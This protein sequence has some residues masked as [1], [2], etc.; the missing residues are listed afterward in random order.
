MGQKVHEV[1]AGLERKLTF[2]VFPRINFRETNLLKGTHCLPMFFACGG[3]ARQS[4]SSFQM[5]NPSCW[6]VLAVWQSK[7]SDPG[8]AT[9]RELQLLEREAD[10]GSD[11]LMCG[12]R[13][14]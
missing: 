1:G 3:S 12:F 6:Q 9:R 14:E 13:A 2:W 10:L 4:E 7:V 11:T 5:Q 8:L